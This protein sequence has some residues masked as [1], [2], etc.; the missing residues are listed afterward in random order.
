MKRIPL[1]PTLLVVLAVAAMIALGVW[2]LQRR[3]EKEAALA[4]YHA[5]LSAP[6]TAYPAN[7]SDATYLFRTVSAH[8]LRVTGWQATGGRMPDG[9]PGW[10]QIA[11]CTRGVEGPGFLVDVGV[12]PDPAA[13]PKWTGGQVRGTATW[14][15]DASSA[16]GRWLSPGPALRLMIVADK[17]VAGLPPSPRPDPSGVPNNHFSYA[18]QW[19]LFAFVAVVIYGLALRRRMK[20]G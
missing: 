19:F 6:A 4:R 2:Q 16:L 15:P 1:I 17:P 11:T 10:R 8:C 13:K 7:S 14:E 5:N 12:T 3:G 20:G 9:S 18:I